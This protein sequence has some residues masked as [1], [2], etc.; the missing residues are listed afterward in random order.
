MVV[1]VFA[2]VFVGFSYFTLMVILGPEILLSNKL[3]SALSNDTLTWAYLTLCMSVSHWVGSIRKGF[4]LLLR[5]QSPRPG[6]HLVLG[7]SVGQV[8]WRTGSFEGCCLYWRLMTIPYRG[9]MLLVS[10]KEEAIFFFFKK[11]G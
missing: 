4:L 11:I 1:C 7:T 6:R 9:L 2:N 5:V 10:A 8:S 3:D